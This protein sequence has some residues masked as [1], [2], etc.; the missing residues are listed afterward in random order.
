[1]GA[2][3]LS[4]R[5]DGQTI[6]DTFFNDIHQAINTDFVGRGSTGIPTAGQNLGT[7]AIP[8]GTVRAAAL[9][10]NGNS[11]D[12]SQVTSPA[13]RVIS[14]KTRST[15]NQPA[16]ITPSASL[17]FTV[18]A[19]TTNLVVDINGATITLST[20]IVKTGITAAP[21]SNNTALINDTLAADQAATRT[22]GEPDNKAIAIDTA[23]SE[24][25]GA[26]GKWAAFKIAGVSTEY[27]IAFVESSI[28]LSKCMRGAFY[29]SS[30]N[31]INRT[32]FS[33]N[34]TLTI[35]KLGWVFADVN[36]TTIDVSY[37]NPTY[38]F[39]APGSPATGDYWYDMS[40]NQWKRYDG[41][42]FQSIS[43]TFIGMI[44][45]DTTA[46]VG[47][48]C[49]AF[50]GNFSNKNTI[51]AELESTE[52]VRGSVWGTHA[53]VAGMIVEFKSSLPQWNIT[54]DLA[55]SVDMYNAT[56][57][58]ST[59]YYMY[60][61]DEG[62]TVI[63]DIEPYYNN[64]FDGYYHPHNPWRMIAK[65]YNN[66]SSN[67]TKVQDNFSQE[68][69]LRLDTVSGYGSDAS[70]KIRRWTNTKKDTG[71][72]W[73]Y[74]DNVGPGMT[75]EIME[76]GRYAISYTDNFTAITSFAITKNASDLTLTPGSGSLTADELVATAT[77][78]GNDHCETIAWTGILEKGDIIRTQTDVTAASQASKT[79][80]SMSKIPDHRV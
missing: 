70:N 52:I 16:F 19:S 30:L 76:R 71:V 3:S 41:G 68:A 33:N 25:V 24:I 50:Y 64:E 22:W 14:G 72:S 18:F 40:I 31:P 73:V 26:V 59:I 9:V 79:Q 13:N 35:M 2:N 77:T 48:R 34:D 58:A 62:E 6:L 53:N 37:T 12:L 28:K 44:I 80:F 1:M 36:A 4:N 63:S 15:S 7:A 27:M 66:G 75:V 51:S 21:S 39:T 8:W 23:G 17:A 10:L 38:G 32:A 45:A 42:T 57:Q 20:D 43:R 60:L 67:L 11:I 46:V 56:E 74:S 54:T 29:D 5:S 65:A 61:S 47:A 49:A 78:S 69:E 55:P